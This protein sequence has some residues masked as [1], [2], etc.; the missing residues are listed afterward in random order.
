MARIFVI[1]EHP[2]ER[3]LRVLVGLGLL[4]IVF[5]GPKTPW[6]YLGLLPIVTGLSGMCPL[7]SVFGFSTCKI[8]SQKSD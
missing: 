4:S 6:G 7:Y 5:I 3:A 8:S 1:N 2:I